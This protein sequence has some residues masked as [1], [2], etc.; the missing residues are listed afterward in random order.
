[1]LKTS[2][3]LP[4]LLSK[5]LTNSSKSSHYRLKGTTEFQTGLLLLLLAEL[6]AFFK[7]EFNMLSTKHGQ[8]NKLR[9]I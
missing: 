1:M 4:Q 9:L 7:T 8:E 5:L 3:N 6:Y 2:T